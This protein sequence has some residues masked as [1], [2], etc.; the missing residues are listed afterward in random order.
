[1]VTQR[2]D[3]Q[4]WD[5]VEPVRVTVPDPSGEIVIDVEIAQP[6][7]LDKRAQFFNGVQLTGKETLWRLPAA[8]LDGV[9]VTGQSEIRDD[10]GAIWLV[11]TAVLLRSGN[12]PGHWECLC[13]KMR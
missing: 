10:S 12:D 13:L 11:Q 3:Y 8:L 4:F 2:G 1:M 6:G 9:E 5:N 7:N